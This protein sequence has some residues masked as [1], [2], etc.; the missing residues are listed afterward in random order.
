MVATITDPMSLSH[1][2]PTS[3]A[4][5]ADP[6]LPLYLLIDPDPRWWASALRCAESIVL[7]QASRLAHRRALLAR[8]L[9]TWA[10]SL[11][12]LS[13]SSH[14]ALVQLLFY[15][16]LRLGWPMSTL[17]EQAT[18]GLGEAARVRAVIR[19]ARTL[20]GLGATRS[21]RAEQALRGLEQM[22]GA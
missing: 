5:F 8:T 15:D 19:L 22:V 21:P 13:I 9:S 7:H 4:H 17:I 11:S 2:P 20:E 14:R 6:A 10:S 16:E 12:S 18:A 3:L 1:A